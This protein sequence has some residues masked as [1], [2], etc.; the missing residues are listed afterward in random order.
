[1]AP[2]TTERSPLPTTLR[3]TSMWTLGLLAVTAIAWAIGMPTALVVL[4]TAPATIACAISALIY[5]KGVEAAAGIRIWLW[6]AIAV[7]GLSF[8]AGL[9]LILMRGPIEQ[10]DACYDRAITQT[11]RRACEV[12]YEDAYKRLVD[13][14]GSYTVTTP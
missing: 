6:I 10:L 4:A 13:K 7:G 8:V 12:Q 9:G 5:S 11:A 2:T 14:Y 1:M 3:R